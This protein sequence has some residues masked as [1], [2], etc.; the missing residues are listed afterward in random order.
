MSFLWTGHMG[1]PAPFHWLSVHKINGP[2]PSGANV[3]LSFKGDFCCGV[4]LEEAMKWYL[5]LP[6]CSDHPLVPNSSKTLTCTLGS[7][8]MQ[9]LQGSVCSTDFSTCLQVLSRI[10]SDLNWKLFQCQLITFP[11]A[12]FLQ[13]PLHT[14]LGHQSTFLHLPKS[15]CNH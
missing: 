6:L 12:A 3:K 11:H 13:L 2:W 15:R 5:W 14:F 4:L 10:D 9:V 8:H 7:F 1:C